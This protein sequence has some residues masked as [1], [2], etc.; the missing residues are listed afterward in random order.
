LFMLG[1]V[2]T[3]AL[4]PL[5]GT[6]AATADASGA[7]RAALAVVAF[8]GFGAA[9]VIA[10]LPRLI[11]SGRLIRFRLA[12]WLG[13]R[14]ISPRDAWQ[15]WILVLASWLTRAFG[16]FL[17]LHALGFAFSLPLAIAF[18]C[19]AAASGALPIAPAGAA[20]QAG[21]GAAILIASGVG[22]ANAVSFA[23]GAQALLIVAGAA[24]L[25]FAAL[26]H[27]G[28]RLALAVF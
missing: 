19:A 7:V 28:R 13:A 24:V 15:A 23:V 14:V 27:G 8:A 11:A 12:R 4:M 3:A 16:L 21:A 26:W 18:L 10:V 2:D 22:T 5:A 20:T 1:L 6:A 17:L 25:V 9:V